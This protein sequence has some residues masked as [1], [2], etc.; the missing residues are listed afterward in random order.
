MY[1]KFIYCLN[2]FCNFT[3][4]INFVV[5]VVVVVVVVC[6]YVLYLVVNKL[7]ISGFILSYCRIFL[8]PFL[9]S[10]SV[11]INKIAK[12]KEAWRASL[13]FLCYKNFGHPFS[14]ANSQHYSLFSVVEHSLGIT[15][16]ILGKS[17]LVPEGKKS[18]L[19]V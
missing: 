4:Q 7:V 12:K 17:T 13:I 2:I 19:A 14:L 5:V 6:V 9:L 18:R 11:I 16:Q 3:V 15:A 10:K 1:F 8:L